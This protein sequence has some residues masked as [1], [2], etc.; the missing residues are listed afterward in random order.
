MG[1]NSSG[2]S[3][4]YGKILHDKIFFSNCGVIEFKCRYKDKDV[5]KQSLPNK[6]ISHTLGKRYMT[7]S[8]TG[9]NYILELVKH[10]H[11][12]Q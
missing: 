12:T 3:V 1:S 9:R 4:Y 2:S 11:T 6:I 7:C 10:K 5:A 8:E